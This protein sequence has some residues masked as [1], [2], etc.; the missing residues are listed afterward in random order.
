MTG[1]INWRWRIFGWDCAAPQL[2]QKRASK[3]TEAPKKATEKPPVATKA[4][5]DAKQRSKNAVAA[6]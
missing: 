4:Q 2:L 5:K 6:K 1:T 3:A